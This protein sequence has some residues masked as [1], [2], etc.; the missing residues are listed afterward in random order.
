MV[1]QGVRDI[2][3]VRHTD[4]VYGRPSRERRLKASFIRTCHIEK[5]AV[6]LSQ[7]VV[8]STGAFGSVRQEA[9][10]PWYAKGLAHPR[11]GSQEY[12]TIATVVEA[13]LITISSLFKPSSLEHLEDSVASRKPRR[14]QAPIPG[15][16]KRLLSHAPGPTNATL[17][18]HRCSD[19][20]NQSAGGYV[21]VI[22]NIWDLRAPRLPSLMCDASQPRDNCIHPLYAG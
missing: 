22:G 21:S 1:S 6:V 15:E 2:S 14:Q 9:A 17:V 10:L 19:Q 5:L 12:L 7:T 20:Y 18:L 11:F 16:D 3:I 4:I 8:L 13:K